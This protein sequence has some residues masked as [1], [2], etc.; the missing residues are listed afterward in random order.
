MALPLRASFAPK[1]CNDPS[2]VGEGASLSSRPTPRVAIVHDY[3]TQRGGA[4]R[5]VLAMLEAFPAAPLHASLYDPTATFPEF[6]AAA[7]HASAL[8]RLPSL[9]RHHRLAFPL[10][11][12]TFSHLRVDADVTVCSSSGWAHGA[13]T[14]GRKVVYCHAPARWLYQPDLYLTE[15]SP[16][17]TRAGLELLAPSLRR[18]DSRAAMSA[19]R[20]LVNSNEVRRRVQDLYRREAEV[21]V[22]PP[23]L[24]PSMPQATVPGI[25]PGFWLCVGRL[26]PYKHHDVVV[27]AFRALPDERLVI[28]GEGP[29]ERHLRSLA[30]PNVT[31]YGGAED[32]QLCWLYAH[33]AAVVTASHEDLGL[34]PLEAASFGKP[35]AALCW[36]GHLD[37]VVHGETGILFDDPEPAAVRAAVQE[38]GRTPWS[39]EGLAAHAA[40]FSRERFI[41]RLRAIVDEVLAAG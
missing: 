20:Y 38:V 32:P 40:A 29:E 25:E 4:E 3:L 17:A 35:V 21:L 7:V 37:T 28:V 5:V 31:F 39:P 8:N 6:S 33:C 11:A 19:D 9:R 23:A 22:P 10:L 18:W 2:R 30:C 16:H 15:R 41:A 12:P 34:T 1:P 24:S 27:E 14:T 13:R 36:G 26:L